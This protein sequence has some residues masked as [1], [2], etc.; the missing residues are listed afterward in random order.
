[1]TGHPLPPHVQAFFTE[2][3][4][5]QLGASPNTVAS[6]RDAFRLLLN[7]AEREIGERPTDLLVEDVDAGLIG[8]FLDHL[9]C[10]QRNSSRT[11]NCQADGDPVVLRPCVPLRTPATTETDIPPRW[12]SFAPFRLLFPAHSRMVPRSPWSVAYISPRLSPG[13]STMRLISP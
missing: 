5:S 7:F 6:F 11:R 1:M 12:M 10:D 3:L 8:R 4:I 2:R 13:V 9:E